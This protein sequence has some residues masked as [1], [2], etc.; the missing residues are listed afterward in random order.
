MGDPLYDLIETI[1]FTET[2]STKIHGLRDKSTIFSTVTDEF[3][4]LGDYS[5]TILL[6]ADDGQF[7]R[8][9]GT[10]I[11]SSV[12]KSMEKV[13]K[14]ILGQYRI[15]LNKSSYFTKVIK[16]G[17]TL[18]AS[19]KDIVGDLVPK[20]LALAL[21]KVL[22]GLADESSIMTPLHLNK[23]II[24][25]LVI[26]SEKVIDPIIPSVRNLA[27]HISTALDL[28]AEYAE[29]MQANSA[30]ESRE[31]ELRFMFDSIE[32]GIVVVDL[33]GNAIEVN[34]ATLRMG[35]F[36]SRDEIIGKD[37]FDFIRE[38][39][40]SRLFEA[41]SS[42]METGRAGPVEFVVCNKQGDEF[43]GEAVATLLRDTSGNISGIIAVFRNI[44]ERKR[45]EEALQRSEKYFRMLIE[46]SPDMFVVLNEDTTIRYGSPS[47][48]KIAGYEIG[49]LIGANALD[50]VHPEDKPYAAKLLDEGK[51][52]PGFTT[53]LETR[54][55]YKDGYYRH[56]EMTGTNLLDDP[57]IEGIVLNF[58]DIE[59]RKQAENAL[60]ES[61]RYFRM[62]I[63]NAP[64]MIVVLNEDTTIRY[65]SP[66]LERLGGYAIENLIGANA[67]DFVHPDDKEYAT[68]L[69]DEGKKIPGFTISLETRLLHSDG[70]YRYVEMTG[71]NFLNDPVIEGIVLNFHDIEVRK[72]AENA[73]RE[74]EE[75]YRA[76]FESTGTPITYFDRDGNIL[77][78][79]K[80]G[81]AY[82]DRDVD[83]LIGKSIYEVFPEKADLFIKKLHKVITTGEGAEVKE[84]VSLPSQDRWL[85]SNIQPAWDSQGNI[86]GVQVISSDITK[87]KSTEERIHHLNA[88]LRAIRNINEL[89]IREED[90]DQMIQQVCNI[91]IET[92]GYESAWI[93]LTNDSAQVEVTAE[94]GIGQNFPVME[95]QISK[96]NWPVCAQRALQQMAPIVI[97]NTIDK[98]VGCPLAGSCSASGFLS[99][100]LEYSGRKY[101]VLCVGN[102]TNY[103]V[104][105]EERA[106]FEEVAG[107]IAFALQ[108]IELD[109]ERARAEEVLRE[110]EDRFK[111]IFEHAN[112][113]I[114]LLD[115][116]G[117]IINV[118]RKIEDIFGYSREEVIGKNYAELGF[119]LP[120][121][122]AEVIEQFAKIADEKGGA[123][124][125]EFEGIHK[126]GNRV[127]IE[128]SLSSIRKRNKVKG[129]LIIVRDVTAR[130]HMEERLNQYSLELEQRLAELQ[131]AYEKLQELD[132]MKDAFLSTVSHELRTPLTSI[133]SF[134]E[135]LIN[136]ETD[137]ET[138]KE[139][140][141][142]INDE[143]DRLTRLINDTLDLAKIESGQMQWETTL[144]DI[145]EVINKSVATTE[146]IA[147]KRNLTVDVE[148]VQDLPKVWGDEDR[149]IQVM[150]NLIGNAIKFSFEGSRIT[151]KAETIKAD[152][153]KHIPE[154]VKV[155][156]I[157][158]GKGIAPED[159]D[160]IF[161]KFTQVGDTLRDKPTG[162]GLGLPISKEIIE[163]YNG[164][165][166]VESELGKG[167]TF[168][169][170][171]PVILKEGVE[172]VGGSGSGKGEEVDE[173]RDTILVV[174]DEANIRRFLSHELTMKGYRVIEAS[175]GEEAIKLVKK[176]LPD[177]ITLDVIM[178][179]MNG[180]DVASELKSYPETRNIPIIIVSATD[181]KQPAYSLGISEFLTKPFDEEAIL[182]KV[183]R[184]LRDPKGSILVVDDDEHLV[185]SVNFELQQRGY[186]TFVA[187]DGDEALKLVAQNP[188]DLIIL[189]IMMPKVDGHQVIKALKAR[190]ETSDIPIIVL[191]GVEV[192]GEKM[193]ALSLGAN[194]YLLKSGGLT[195]LLEA[196]ANILA[197]TESTR[198]A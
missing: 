50:F 87:L 65:G 147:S 62:L 174:D 75:K 96:G 190:P 134:A 71:A 138:Q 178:P 180:F 158:T 176:Y 188:P 44:T 26:T 143:S 195:Q 113:E 34:N 32:D 12:L 172:E 171:L 136:Y 17:E 24:G 67:L 139:F 61:E 70:S 103:H 161:E 102:S 33:K 142:I 55:L 30:L 141:H 72:Q 46:N 121:H 7:L 167:S 130:K 140:L 164:K 169:F 192:V 23:E 197:T 159:Q 14:A 133:K 165:I 91:L 152:D 53:T 163:R 120:K 59:V 31:F 104:G 6:L 57:E 13:A 153:E 94:A 49:N 146:A 170:S 40:R 41:L 126:N 66:S 58:R 125:A 18:L 155:S 162:T 20:T 86:F 122:Q 63:E 68:K 157:D 105:E 181:D 187:H 182:E 19:G 151:I 79:N 115:P 47:L 54:L 132:K 114:V 179:D 5:A 186:S 39:D 74:S 160:M 184:L 21:L 183:T 117:T 43:P 38:S 85:L 93:A 194:E 112:D 145:V 119:F 118:N 51:K 168:S 135:I 106:L 69:L 101:G 84:M 89:I 131:V 45:I 166:W 100:R 99:V 15:D 28:A 73:L 185:K 128:A 80:V 36:D 77:L 107:D 189:D 116:K 8:I 148:K 9:E 97:E 78:I 60:K 123:G 191:T 2:V 92:R 98:C 29:R 156:V 149:F 111:E 52:I 25:A 137:E 83:D 127:F 88:V 22:K 64:D 175:N 109:N 48:A 144:V 124:L 76:L 82:L 198:Q 129:L 177:L 173:K 150:T 42:V 90:R 108:E 37:A 56:V 81:A 196:A 11:P 1:R 110:S 27:L 3:S 154:Q 16:D 4:K 193:K 35:G 95:K 10:S